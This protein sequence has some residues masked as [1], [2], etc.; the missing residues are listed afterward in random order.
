MDK[1]ELLETIAKGEDSFTEFKKDIESS[2]E[3]VAEIC[4]FANSKGGRLILG[5][6]DEGEIVGLK[7]DWSDKISSWITTKL[8]PPLEDITIQ[9]F[10]IEEKLI[11]VV[12]IPIG[13]QKPYALLRKGTRLSLIHISEPTRRS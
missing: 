7:R 1:L 13:S 10:L 11:I 4:A 3:I 8:D 5:V 2:D 9:K 12:E 6:S